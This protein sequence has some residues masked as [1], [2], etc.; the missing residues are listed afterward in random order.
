MQSVVPAGM[1]HSLKKKPA[2]LKYLK[3]FG[4][5]KFG[6]LFTVSDL[7]TACL[8]KWCDTVNEIVDFSTVWHIGTA[9]PEIGKCT[10]DESAR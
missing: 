8:I 7:F 5:Q 9:C 4:K 2:N 1:F 3:L 10:T 6:D